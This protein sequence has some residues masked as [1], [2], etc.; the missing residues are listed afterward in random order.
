MVAVTK[1]VPSKPDIPRFMSSMTLESDFRAERRS[2]TIPR[3]PGISMT[4]ATRSP[5]RRYVTCRK[6]CRDAAPAA[7]P[8]TKRAARS[9]GVTVP[10]TVRTPSTRL[11][12]DLDRTSCVI[13][14]T[15]GAYP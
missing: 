3:S 1:G 7:R 2:L 14:G 8:A 13:G 15:P 5:M 12:C 11:R 9:G 10:E 4:H 6:D